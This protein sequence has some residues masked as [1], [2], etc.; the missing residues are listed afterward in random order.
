VNA[1]SLIVWKCGKC[2]SLF[3]AE[4]YA[5]LCCHNTPVYDPIEKARKRAERKEEYRIRRNEIRREMRQE[6]KSRKRAEEIEHSE[7]L[8]EI[9]H[10]EESEESEH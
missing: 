5:N 1:T 3:L 6:E 4:S 10:S 9:E 7:C 2:E 8:E